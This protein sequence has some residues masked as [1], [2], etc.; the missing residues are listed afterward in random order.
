MN[1]AARHQFGFFHGTLDGLHRGLDVDHHAFLQ[2]ARGV[3]ADADDLELPVGLD[4]ADD[5]DDLA[6]AYVQSALP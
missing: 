1:L 5:G 3:T 6:G 4:F 2:A